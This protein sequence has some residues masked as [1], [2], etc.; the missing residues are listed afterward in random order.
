MS[1]VILGTEIIGKNGIKLFTR[2]IDFND[3]DKIVEI[4][5]WA[6]RGKEGTF[7]WATE[8]GLV[9]GPRITPEMLHSDLNTDSKL[10]KL[11]LIEHIIEEKTIDGA[12]E[13]LEAT[14][15]TTTTANTQSVNQKRLIVGCVKIERESLESKEAVIG[16]LSVDP[17]YQSSGIGSTLIKLAEKECG[18]WGVT[19]AHLHVVHVRHTLIN[20]YNKLGYITTETTF[21]FEVERNVALENIHFV[22][23]VKNL[24]SK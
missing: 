1:E 14:T 9:T 19:E 5:N 17:S 23:L 11:M 16:M 18:D 13:A 20:W 4:V 22:L 10:M 3:T 8:K 7:P 6:Y 2:L 24:L 21:P 15:T 12:S